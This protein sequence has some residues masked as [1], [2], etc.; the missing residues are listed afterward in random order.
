M[1]VCALRLLA[2][3]ALHGTAVSHVDLLLQPCDPSDTQQLWTFPDRGLGYGG[4][5]MHQARIAT[6][7]NKPFCHP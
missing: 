3:L 7:G 2:L 6:G 1:P 4:P 5:I